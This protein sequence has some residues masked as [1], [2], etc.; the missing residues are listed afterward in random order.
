[1][2]D[3]SENVCRQCATSPKKICF[4]H[5]LKTLQWGT[6]PGAYRRTSGGSYYDEQSLRDVGMPTAEEVEDERSDF[7]RRLTDPAYLREE[8]V[9]Q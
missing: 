3:V 1:M 9:Q 5:K 2:P 4:K 6:V 7:R 8:V